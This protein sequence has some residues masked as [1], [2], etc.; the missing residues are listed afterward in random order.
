MSQQRG[1]L[2]D[3]VQAKA[4]ELLGYELDQTELRLM[5][6]VQY[7]MMNERNLDPR[8]MNGDD[9]AVLKKWR[10]AGHIEGGVSSDS[11]RLEKKFWD[12]LHEILWLAYVDLDDDS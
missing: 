4:K 2:T 1:Q 9:R 7:R 5:P 11:L 8:H 10:D 6:Y 12:A 3:R